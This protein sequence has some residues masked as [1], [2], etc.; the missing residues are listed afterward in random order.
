MGKINP[1]IYQGAHLL[2][3]LNIVCDTMEHCNNCGSAV[4]DQ[5]VRVFA[6][7]DRQTVRVCPFCED[8]I[9]Q[10]AETRPAQSTRR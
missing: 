1:L 4:T 7:D 10:G 5:Y 8:L 6:P 9:R 2:S 3:I